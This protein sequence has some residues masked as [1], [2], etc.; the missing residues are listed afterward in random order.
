M[1]LLFSYGALQRADVQLGTFGRLL[2]GGTHDHL[3]GYDLS[4]VEINDGR[5]AQALS[6]PRYAN[7]I[8]S[9][10]DG[11]RVNGM[12]FEVTDAELLAVDR[13]LRQLG[14]KRIAEQLA[15]SKRM[16]WVYLFSL[17]SSNVETA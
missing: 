12:V 4:D 15:S 7:I 14:Y 11:S 5:S 2:E 3:I 16:A 9:A 17:P 6:K 13:H 8:Y 1:P 10:R